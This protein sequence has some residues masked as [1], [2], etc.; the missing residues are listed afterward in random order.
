MKDLD[1]FLAACR[2]CQRAFAVKLDLQGYS[3]QFIEELLEVSGSFIRK[4]RTQ[5]DKYGIE[6]LYL[7]YQGS[8]GYLSSK[9]RAEVIAF[10]KTKDYYSVEALREYVDEHYAVVYQSKQSYYDLLHEAHIGWKKTEKVHPARDDGK[11]LAKRAVI[12]KH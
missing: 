4:W 5:Y 6:R 10:S 7:Q 3:S 9:E 2:E 12:K 11:V 1:N 8:Q